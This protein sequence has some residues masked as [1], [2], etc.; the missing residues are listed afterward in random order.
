MGL[1]HEAKEELLCDFAEYYHIYDLRQFSVQY[2]A[3][4]AKGLRPDSRTKMKISDTEVT[5]EKMAMATLI[6][7]VNTLIWQNTKGGRTGRN[8]PQSVAA[9]LI[10]RGQEKEIE[11]FDSVID[12]EK[13]RARIIMG[14]GESA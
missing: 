6:D 13:A 8:R 9:K 5:F 14:G 2:I 7:G 1:L 4:L 3:I 10:N 12:F 11:G